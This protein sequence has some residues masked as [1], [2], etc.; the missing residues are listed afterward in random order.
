MISPK[1]Q[2]MSPSTAILARRSSSC[3]IRLCGVKPSGI[4]D[5]RLAD[6]AHHRRVDR[7]VDLRLRLELPRPARSAAAGADGRVAGGLEDLLELLLVV[8][9]QLLGVLD[10]DVAAADQLLGVELA[11]AAL[12]V[13]DLVHLR[14]GHRRVVALVVAA[15][16]VADQVDH[17][18]L[19]ERL[20]V[21]EGQPRH[22]Y[23]GLGVVAVDVEDRRLDHPG[24][25][26]AVERRAAV[27]R[28]GGEADLVVDHDVH[29]C[30]RCGSRAAARG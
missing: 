9:Q 2:S 18:V 21:F 5:V 8:P 16:A 20:A 28:R 30:R 12:G 11:D 13:D 17:D 14:V 1:P 7:R 10:G 4:D 23:D 19:V 6:R 22:P 3:W 29:R 25:V 24:D 26:G 15:P 27:L